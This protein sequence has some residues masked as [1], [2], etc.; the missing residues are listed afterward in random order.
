MRRHWPTVRL[1]LIVLILVLSGWNGI[2]DGLTAAKQASVQGV[3]LAAV[4]QLLSGV[5]AAG[6]LF[7]M[8][9]EPPRVFSMLVFWGIV[10]TATASLAPIVVGGA[11]LTAGVA[12]GAATAIAVAL[13]VWGWRAHE[14]SERGS[15][16]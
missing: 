14:E 5:S 8:V 2:V 15:A 16:E 1:G 3:R 4:L 12:A 9:M 6:A 7:L 13:V 10:L 11:P